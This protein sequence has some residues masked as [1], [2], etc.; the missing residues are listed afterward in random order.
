MDYAVPQQHERNQVVLANEK[1]EVERQK[2]R[3]RHWGYHCQV[4][5][6]EVNEEKNLFATS[7]SFLNYYR[8]S[9]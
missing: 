1:E 4:P 9:A 2:Q 7:F 5:E 8:I 3:S 6:A